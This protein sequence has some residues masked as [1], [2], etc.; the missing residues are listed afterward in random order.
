MGRQSGTVEAKRGVGR[1]SVRCH[2]QREETVG[3]GLGLRRGV[4]Q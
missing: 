2:G 3:V 4:T 1:G